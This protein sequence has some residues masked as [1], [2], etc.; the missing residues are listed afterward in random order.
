MFIVYTRAIKNT[1]WISPRNFIWWW[2][3][4]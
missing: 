3:R 2:L 4:N 1:C